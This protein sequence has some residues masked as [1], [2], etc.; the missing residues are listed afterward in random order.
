MR[1]RG[2]PITAIARA[3]GCTKSTALAWTKHVRLSVQQRVSL[4][5]QGI[6]AALNVLHVSIARRAAKH[7]TE[8]D[9]F[10]EVHKHEPLF[11]AGVGLYWGEGNKAGRTLGIVNSDPLLLKV[12]LR[13]CR[14][15]L[16]GYALRFS[17]QAHAD[18]SRRSAVH[19]WRRA[20]SLAPDAHVTFNK[21]KR[22]RASKLVRGEAH[23][24]PYGTMAVAVRRGSAE[25][26]RKMARFIE[27]MSR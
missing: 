6:K 1:E 25:C 27:L 12:W 22:S 13:W 10:W 8:A 26:H 20:L 11:A 15:Y 5:S 21:V 23:P 2:C 3:V 14:C 18:V 19:F 4:R 7:I 16:K 9:A 24:M 17:I